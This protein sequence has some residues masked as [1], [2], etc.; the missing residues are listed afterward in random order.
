MKRFCL[1]LLITT[2]QLTWSQQ[3]ARHHFACAGTGLDKVLHEIES[4]FDIRYSYADSIVSPKT[5]TLSPGKYSLNELN[6]EISA[7]TALQ[8]VQI[9]NRYFSVHASDEPVKAGALQPIL[10]HGFLSKGIRKSGNQVIITPQKVEELPGVTDADILLS[11]QQLPGVKSPNETATG[12]HVRG[13]TPDQNLILWD[14]IRMYHP[15]HLFGMI[16]GFNPNVEQT[17][18]F[19]NKAANPKYGE[20]IS[21]IIDIKP[22]DEIAEKL[23]AA[24]GINGLN[25]DFYLQ[26]PL[27]KKK[28]GI[29]FSARKSF[30]EWLQ[31]PAFNSLAD[32]VFQHTRFRDFD[33]RNQFSFWDYSAKITFSPDKNS[34]LSITG[35]SI[36]NSLDYTS[37]AN[38][39]RT[40][41]QK[42]NIL[43]DGL[44]LNWQ[45]KY[46]DKFSHRILIH[47][48]K[49]DF[50]YEKTQQSVPNEF[51]KFIKLNRIT[52]SGTEVN[53][54]YNSSGNFGVDFGYQLS[55]NDVSHSFTGKNENLEIDLDWQHRFNTTH[56]GYIYLKYKFRLWDFQAGARYN[57]F[58]KVRGDSFEPRFFICRKLTDAFTVNIS[59][60]K[61]S[62]V[63][64]QARESVAN[65]LSLENYVW[66]LSDD[67]ESPVQRAD[68]FTAGFN[69]KTK[70]WLADVDVY[71][72]TIDGITSRSFGFM[73]Q[74]DA[75]ARNGN[76]YTQGAEFLLQKSAPSWRAWLTY[77]Y[78][79]SRNRYENINGGRY[80]PVSADINHAFT[81]SFHKKWRRLSAALGWFWHTGRPYS[82]LNDSGAI[83]SFNRERLPVYHRLD[84]S[85][86]YQFRERKSWSG[87]FGFSVLNL[88]NRKAVITKEYD[89][90]LTTIGDLETPVYSV[91]TYNSLGLTPNAF[92]RV[93]F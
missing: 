75:A 53:F 74:S 59:Y 37:P 4:K 89:R 51:E 82:R 70:S 28:I 22:T 9:D 35:I 65:D 11:L 41:N 32:K 18:H 44:S 19:F 20:R 50:D 27:L 93:N 68:H 5:I 54:S 8:I 60:E 61:K 71:Y 33:T 45:Q 90:R 91:R 14:G 84:L 17:V 49:Y 77:T 80:F 26:A 86:A 76:G 29:Q 21:S 48:S 63:M 64:S 56:A 52:D 15:G 66:I 67:A 92:I 3:S 1:F 24:A 43:N 85:A 79:D 46:S 38:D 2:T 42:M 78:Q 55:G 31:A 69:Y 72:K 25:A 12:L 6:A 58:N 13:G 39:S 73:E 47:F 88:Y 57:K 30:T 34:L 83:T 40:I 23:K 16:S 10:V 7:Q 36:G 87:K 81:A 62:Q